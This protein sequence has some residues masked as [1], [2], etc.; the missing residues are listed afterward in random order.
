MVEKHILSEKGKKW[1]KERELKSICE[2]WLVVLGEAVL[3]EFVNGW[4]DF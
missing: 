1:V 2:A 4:K 3:K